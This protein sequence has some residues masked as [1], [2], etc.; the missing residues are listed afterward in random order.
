MKI[1][2][3]N[4]VRRYD[5]EPNSEHEARVFNRADYR[6]QNDIVKKG[7]QLMKKTTILAIAIGLALASSPA[8]HAWQSFLDGSALPTS[9]WDPFINEG[10]TTIVDVGGN[11]ALRMDSPAHSEGVGTHYNEYFDTR[12]GETDILGAARFRLVEF[13]PTGIENLLGVTV[14]G[15]MAIAP[16]IT[17]VDGNYWVRSYTSQEPILLLGPAVANEWHTAYVLAR[18]DGTAKVWWDGAFV[19]DGPV[20][21]SPDFDGYVEFGSGVYWET[22]AHTVVDFDWVGSGDSSDLIPEPRTIGLAVLGG[23][24]IFALRCHRGA[25]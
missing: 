9:P 19:L 16:S 22:T 18:A 21:D 4:A 23:I 11:F 2:L 7:A 14:G 1:L 25:R 15:A 6:S 12:F 13:S 10:S 3:D 20:T 5:S 24:G 17:L 8:A